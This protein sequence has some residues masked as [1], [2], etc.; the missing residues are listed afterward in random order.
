M[1]MAM[2]TTTTTDQWEPPE[3]ATRGQ[4]LA[5][6]LGYFSV[7]LGLTQ[8]LAPHTL[9]S[10]VGVRQQRRERR[11]RIRWVTALL[12]ARE[13][14]AGIGLLA[15]RERPRPWAWTR[16]AGDVMD[17]A[18]LGSLF[19]LRRTD[20]QRLT[21]A[22]GAVAGVTALDMLAGF[23]VGQ[24][25]VQRALSGSRRV[26]KSIT[27]RRSPD[28]VYRFWRELDNLPF[29]MAHVERVE[30]TGAGRSHWT[31]RAPA[32]KTVEWDAEIVADEPGQRLAWRALPGGDIEHEGVVRFERA[33]GGRGTEVHVELTYGAPG[34]VLGAA[35][36]K[37]FGE[38]PAQ[39]LAGDLRRL[40]QVLETGEVVHSDASVAAGPHPARPQRT[41]QPR[42]S[43]QV[44]PPL[45]PLPTNH[46]DGSRSNGQENRR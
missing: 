22:L 11:K 1:T 7:G 37:L 18:L 4:G 39:Q 45:P 33:P 12:G 30:R 14:G 25:E 40:K 21:W 19:A 20:K 44:A 24:R 5:R 15:Q 29:F 6:A 41:A 36:A 35:V 8:L 43:V 34:G 42:I 28:E 13:L 10:L 3:P 27:I 38:E 2:F 32:G 9:A 17:L 46:S 26:R 16:V 31:V 23:G